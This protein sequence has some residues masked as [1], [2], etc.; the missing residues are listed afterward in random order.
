MESRREID[1]RPDGKAI[2][3]IRNKKENERSVQM[4]NDVP[5]SAIEFFRDQFL[6]R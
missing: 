3:D 6:G 5:Q 1:C 4:K 2:N